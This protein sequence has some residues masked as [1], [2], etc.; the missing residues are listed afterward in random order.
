V[1]SAMAAGL[2]RGGRVVVMTV[3]SMIASTHSDIQCDGY[4]MTRSWATIRK[5]MLR[6]RGEWIISCGFCGPKSCS[7]KGSASWKKSE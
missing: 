3:F 1:T 4:P 7:L 2:E 6:L 5:R